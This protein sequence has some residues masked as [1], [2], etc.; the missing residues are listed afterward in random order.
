MMMLR[1]ILQVTTTAASFLLLSSLSSVPVS[2]AEEDLECGMYMAISSTSTVDETRWGI[3]A[4]KDIPNGAPLGGPDVAINIFNLQGNTQMADENEEADSLLAS[5][6]DFFEQ[7]IWVP[8]PSGSQFDLEDGRT[9]TAIPGAGVL[10]GFNPKLTNA[11]W[12]HSAAYFRPSLGEQPGVN[13]PGRGAY[14]N[15]YHVELRSK[16]EI[17]AGRE[18]FLEYGDNWE[19]E[20]KE[21]DLTTEDYRKLDATVEKM[22]NFFDKYND[23][24]D[25]KAKTDIYDFLIRDVMGAAAGAGKGRKIVDLLPAYPESLPKVKE[26]GGSLAY[27]QPKSIRS[28]AWLQNHG[29][30]IDNIGP[31]A[32]TIPHAGRGAF[33]RRKIKEG[34]LVAPV[35]LVHLPAGSMMDM[36]EIGSSDDGGEE[37]PVYYK[38][39]DEV[40]G[41]QLLLNYLYGHPESSMLFFPSGSVSCLINHSKEPNAKLVWSTHPGH[42]RHWYDM[43]P[44]ELLTMETMYIGLLIEVVA[45]RDIEEGEEIFIDY[46]DEWAAAWEAHVKEFETKVASG[47]LPKDWPIRALDLNDEFSKK[48]FK[49]PDELAMEPYPNNV[50]LKCFVQVT[51]EVIP[52]KIDGKPVREWV[53]PKDGVFDSDSLEDCTVTDYREVDNGVMSAIPYNYTVSLGRDG[54]ATRIKDVPH[55]AF[56][57]VDKPGTGDQFAQ[58]PFRHYISIPDD[59]FPQGPW[60]DLKQS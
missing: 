20:A 60:R 38:L 26:S 49:N 18:I 57:F 37:G 10:G 15:F 11:D 50:M 9:V 28:T 4:G 1:Q 24:L 44:E 52:E 29:R 51:P 48:A 22:A 47:D 12:N 41:K 3:Y 16:D 27:S 30:C 56:V 34:G 33:A 55:R 6:V 5:T 42:Q 36:H 13:H 53:M 32:S 23:E 2:L 54:G 45:L 14:S 7:F 35:P 43:S 17:P 21:E 40:Q 46:G 58:N 31:G 39:S 25:E 59:V 19:E 8:I